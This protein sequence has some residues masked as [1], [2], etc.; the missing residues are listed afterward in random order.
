MKR[1][2]LFLTVWLL[3]GALGAQSLQELFQKTKDQTKGGD[4]QGA[5]KTLHA[6]DAESSKPGNESLRKQLEGPMAFYRGVCE[7]N[8][9]QA[10][11]AR[12][13][14]EAFLAVQPNAS[15]DPAMYS[16]KAT[17]AFEAARKASGTPAATSG[18]DKSPSLFRAYQEFKAP[19]NVSEPASA[20]WADGPVQWIMTAEEKKT[21]SGLSSDGERVE[22]VQKFWESRNPKPGDPDNTFRTGFERRVAFADANFVQDEKK[23]GSLTDRGMVF[24]L[25]G[26]PTYGGRRPIRTGEDTSEAAGMSTT[27]TLD[28]ATAQASAAHSSPSGKVTSGQAAAIND[29]MTGPG[30]K[31]AESNNNYQEVW[32]Y[33]KE[34]LPKGVGYQQVDVVFVTK[35]GYGV[36]VMQRET[37]TLATLEAA[38][39]KPE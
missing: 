13:S 27:S 28:L 9:D 29:Q 16:K 22:F 34:L 5:L 23:R 1:V 11:A 37:P 35:K 20:T 18:A 14:F 25:L 10:D 24:V 12:A 31:A 38:R 8:L 2:S 3:A 30:T 15:I 32:H 6:L 33:R 36:N 39:K 17:A 26:P 21:W 19:P 4:W 7:A